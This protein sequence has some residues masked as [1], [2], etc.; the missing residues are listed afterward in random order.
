MHSAD[1]GLAILLGALEGGERVYVCGAHDGRRVACSAE[2]S[3]GCQ[4]LT[5]G[6]SRGLVAV[7]SDG[8]VIPTCD[9]ALAI[10]TL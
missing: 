3:Y 7:D 9:L 2:R 4:A 10:E 6:V 1:Y 8:E 5:R